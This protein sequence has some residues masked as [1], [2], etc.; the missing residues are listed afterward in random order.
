MRPRRETAMQEDRTD[1]RVRDLIEAAV[2]SGAYSGLV[3]QH[4]D[5]QGLVKLYAKWDRR[6][7]DL[8]SEV[9]GA[10]GQTAP[11]K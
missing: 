9:A 3:R 4:P 6:V 10:V 5:S 1:G 2:M 7:T 8:A 11:R